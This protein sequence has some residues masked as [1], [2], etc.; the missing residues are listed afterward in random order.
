LTKNAE[1]KSCQRSVF[2][3]IG[4]AADVGTLIDEKHCSND[5]N[6]DFWDS[7]RAAWFIRNARLERIFVP[8]AQKR[9]FVKV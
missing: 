6:A 2:I 8:P 7:L 9:I 4:N 3:S 5:P 1:P